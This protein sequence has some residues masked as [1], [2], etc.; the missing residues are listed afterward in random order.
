MALSKPQ[1]LP[2]QLPPYLAYG[3]L[4]VASIHEA[5]GGAIE[6]VYVDGEDIAYR[7]HWASGDCRLTEYLDGREV[8]SGSGV[9]LEGALFDLGREQL[10]DEAGGPPPVYTR[11][12]RHI[13]SRLIMDKPRRPDIGRLSYPG[14]LLVW[15][16]LFVSVGEEIPIPVVRS[17]PER[18]SDAR[19]LHPLAPDLVRDAARLTYQPTE[20]TTVERGQLVS[21]SRPLLMVEELLDALGDLAERDRPKLARPHSAFYDGHLGIGWWIDDQPGVVAAAW[22]VATGD[23][24]LDR[25]IDEAEGNGQLHARFWGRR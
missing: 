21:W 3:W 7:V 8:G 9:D 14:L 11:L 16:T 23:F 6:A 22:A 10:L 24:D 25:A 18:Q 20:S 15:V 4:D 12:R 13:A 1:L 19:L 17:I 5:D 2:G